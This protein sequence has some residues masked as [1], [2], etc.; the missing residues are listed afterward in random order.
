VAQ[1]G[2]L[3]WGGGN[4]RPGVGVLGSEANLVSQK[5]ESTASP[6]DPCSKT[7]FTSLLLS[8]AYLLAYL[9]KYLAKGSSESQ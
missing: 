8:Q 6:V 3:D 5:S 7:L 1:S 9:L 2:W 4:K